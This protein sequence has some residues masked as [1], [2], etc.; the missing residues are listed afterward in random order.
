[1][2]FIYPAVFHEE[3]DGKYKDETNEYSES[4]F[5]NDYGTQETYTHSGLHYSGKNKDVQTY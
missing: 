3:K 5:R 4:V 1:M 2:K